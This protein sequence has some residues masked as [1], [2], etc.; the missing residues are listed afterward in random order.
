KMP[1]YPVMPIITFVSVV[2][3]FWGLGAEAKLYTLAWF[4]IGL[5]IYLIYG[6]KHSK[7]GKSS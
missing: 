1:F 4:I 2:I 3:V 5:I 7:K 6:V